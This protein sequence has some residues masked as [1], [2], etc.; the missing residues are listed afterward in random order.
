MVQFH[1][2]HSIPMGRTGTCEE[3]AEPIAFLADR[4]V[5]GYMTGQSINVDGGTTLQHAMATYSFD[6]IMKRTDL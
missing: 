5:S 4:K 2:N 6:D 3:I 1:T